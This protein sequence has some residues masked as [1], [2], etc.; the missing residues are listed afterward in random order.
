MGELE[1]PPFASAHRPPRVG[2][3]ARERPWMP[4]TAPMSRQRS[5]DPPIGRNAL[6]DNPVDPRVKPGLV[7][8]RLE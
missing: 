1:Q 3:L 7:R 6:W 5:S 8:H 4:R 2:E